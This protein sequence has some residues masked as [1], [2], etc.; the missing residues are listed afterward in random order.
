MSVAVESAVLKKTQV[1]LGKYIKKPP[2]T[3]KLLNKPPFRFL[4][5]IINVIIKETGFLSGL[6]TDE[7]LSSENIKDKESKVAFLQK[8]IDATALATGESLTVRPSKIVAGHEAD[9]TNIWLQALGKAIEQNV[10]STEAVEQVLSGVKP[11]KGKKTDKKLD[12][13]K[14][15]TEK[16]PEK[17]KKEAAG[18][19]KTGK[20]ISPKDAKSARARVPKQGTKPPSNSR[21]AQPKTTQGLRNKPPS[22]P[23]DSHQLTVQ[24]KN[25]PMIKSPTKDT[26]KKGTALKGSR[27][28]DGKEKTSRK[29]KSKEDEKSSSRSKSGRSRGSREKAAEEAGEADKKKDESPKS[30]SSKSRPASRVG[31]AIEVGKENS[32]PHEVINDDSTISNGHATEEEMALAPMLGSSRP[33]SA[34]L[35]V[36]GDTKEEEQEEV[37]LIKDE[38]VE[39][40]AVLPETDPNP[41]DPEPA[42]LEGISSMG[43]EDSATMN[44]PASLIQVEGMDGGKEEVGEDQGTKDNENNNSDIDPAILKAMAPNSDQV[45]GEDAPPSPSQPPPEPPDSGVGS[46]ESP[47][48][49]P[50]SQQQPPPLPTPPQRTGPTP[51]PPPLRALEQ[52]DD[53]G[54][55]GGGEMPTAPP[56][57]MQAHADELPPGDQPTE[58]ST[59][60]R[61]GRRSARPPSAR[62][63]PPRVRERREVSK[64]EQQPQRPGTAKPV[65]NVILPTAGDRDNNDDD[66][67]D[68]FTVEETKPAVP[69]DDPTF[70]PAASGAAVAAGVAAVG[71]DGEGAGLLVAQ[72]LETKK[73]MEDGRRNAF[74]PETPG[75]RRVPIEQAL[76]SDAN[77]RKERELIQKDVQKLSTSIQSITRSVN[78]LAKMLDYLQEDLDSMHKELEMWRTENIQL[79]QTL[80]R[81]QSATEQS[82]EPLRSQLLDL[83]TAVQEQRDRLSAVKSSILK[84]D[85]KIGRLIAGINLNV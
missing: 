70:D 29:P 71:E 22:N 81:E 85:D 34:K 84:N 24:A 73:E 76:L 40:P 49:P 11:D 75:H 51:A 55:T 15:K 3:D 53:A 69:L 39:E 4:H 6:Y 36:S 79:A 43:E 13:S 83:E 57:S 30:K 47:K 7:E 12:K 50:S 18:T 62:P 32:P 25:I 23:K 67:D 27:S 8:C 45:Q 28:K 37:D 2:L 56:L 16:K 33:P 74:S 17:S 59:R 46:L 1:E 82:L 48:Q 64:E 77:R 5:D 20:D 78:P 38:G 80:K 68:N 9:K 42:A 72:I 54:N 63:A 60:P 65:A 66:D 10:D 52:F 31:Q 26:E 58:K 35:D 19:N 41:L 61:T 14:E 44:G 21:A